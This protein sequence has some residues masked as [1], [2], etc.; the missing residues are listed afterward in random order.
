M[1]LRSFV[2]AGVPSLMNSS[3]PMLPCAENTTYLWPIAAR[4]AGDEG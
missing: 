3:K 1:S 4:S 2:P